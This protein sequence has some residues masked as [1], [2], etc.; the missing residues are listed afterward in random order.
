MKLFIRFTRISRIVIFLMAFNS[1]ILAFQPQVNHSAVKIGLLITDNKS[2]AAKQG[3]ELAVK[4]ANESGGYKDIPFQ[5]VIRSMEGPWG[6]GSKETVN[7]IFKDE[8]CAILGSQDGRNAHLAEQVAAK[9]GT[10]FLSAWTGDPTLSQ[11]FV[12]WFFNCAPNDNQQAETLIE[13]IYHKEKIFR[14]AVVSD[15]TYGSRM[16]LKSFL[17]K[18]VIAGMS[19][20][21][22][23]S[24]ENYPA[25]I[26]IIPDEI[27]KKDIRCIVLLGQPSTSLKIVRQ[28][29]LRN[30]NQIVFGSIALGNENALSEKEI[31]GCENVRM[32]VPADFPGKAY[33]DF[34]KDYQ[35]FYGKRPGMVATY[36]FD[37]MSLLIEA[38]R[39]AGTE[40]ED[41]QNFLSKANFKGVTGTIQFDNNGNRVWNGHTRKF[42]NGNMGSS[43]ETE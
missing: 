34:C 11:A 17:K 2:V 19:E 5:L 35:H 16:A 15:S 29:Q 20:P 42:K 32:I 21:L 40:R 31:K 38:I 4:K 12:P 43:D 26:G 24:C 37:G 30:M 23:F 28:I 36:A 1:V 9:T 14:L 18:S 13:E 25:D 22:Q 27:R 6:T 39:N 3:A 8:V 33:R 7:L 10:L 41:I